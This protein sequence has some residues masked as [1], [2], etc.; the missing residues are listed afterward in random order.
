MKKKS[1][2]VG[3]INPLLIALLKCKNIIASPVL[4]G[5]RD[6][7]RNLESYPM[8]ERLNYVVV[9]TVINSMDYHLDAATPFLPFGKLPYKCCNGHGRVI[10]TNDTAAVYCYANS[11]KETRMVSIFVINT[12]KNG[13]EGSYTNKMGFF[14]SMDTKNSIAKS[15]VEAYKKNL[16]QGFPEDFL[17]NNIGVDSLQLVEETVSV[18]FD[19]T[20]SS[21]K[22]ADIFYFN[23]MMGDAIMKNPFY[24]A[25]R[26]YFVEMPFTKDDNYV[27]N[28]EIPWGYKIDELPKSARIMLNEN[29]R[30]FE[31]LISADATIIQMRCR[32]MLKK[33]NF[34]GEDYQTLRN[35]YGYIV[36]KKQSK[37]YLKK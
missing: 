13:V 15:G 10:S 36:K 6:F 22:N 29:E 1:G 5:T 25:E 14:E 30:M 2:I 8:M 28:M 20:L 16:Q 23:P 3:D 12:E 31:Y 18:K 19:F 7:G 11:L 9:K 26:I 34:S 37:L 4:L 24:A 21:F 17:I 27:L 32:I 35:F 33:A